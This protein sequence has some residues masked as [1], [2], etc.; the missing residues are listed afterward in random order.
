MKRYEALF[1]LNTAGKEE[2]IDELIQG[3]S[4]EIE[5]AGGKIEAVQKMEK[6]SFARVADKKATAGFYVN[7]VFQCEKEQAAELPGRFKM[8]D[9]VFRI[10]ISHS[11]APKPEPEQE[12][13]PAA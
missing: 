4:A 10:L 11:P 13:A 8:N 7:Y 2:G 6:K 12:P 9:N 1:I 5:S 3:I